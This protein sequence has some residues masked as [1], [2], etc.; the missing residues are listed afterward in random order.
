MAIDSPQTT[1][2]DL[3]RFSDEAGEM[4]RRNVDRP[5]TTLR[6]RL[7]A[8]LLAELERQAQEGRDYTPYVGNVESD[9]RF[10]VDGMVDLE[11]LVSAIMEAMRNE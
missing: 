10:L 11:P 1:R 5:Q 6:D 7:T 2:E 4:V 8:A 9:G 3:E